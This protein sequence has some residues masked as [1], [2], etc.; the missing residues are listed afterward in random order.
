MRGHVCSH[1]T[2]WTTGSH[3]IVHIEH[4]QLLVHIIILCVVHV[5]HAL[6]GV[7]SICIVHVVNALLLVNIKYSVHISHALI[8]VHIT[9]CSYR[10]WSAA[11]SH[12]LLFIQ[13]M[14]CCWFTSLVVHTG[15]AL[16]CSATGSHCVV[17]TGYALLLVHIA[18]CSYR[19]CSATGSHRVL[20][21]QAMLCY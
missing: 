9:C 6:L 15:Y 21:I 4:A 14:L 13:A 19:L 20:F 3:H 18:C 8:L 17:H 10:P 11:G 5:C 1:R 12:R 16:L 2:W 7:H